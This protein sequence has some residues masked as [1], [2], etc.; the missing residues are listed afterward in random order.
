MSERR[1]PHCRSWYDAKLNKC[2]FCNVARYAHNSWLVVA[3]MND[4]LYKQA[5]ATSRNV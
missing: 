4:V 1:C 2:S 3:K 5:A